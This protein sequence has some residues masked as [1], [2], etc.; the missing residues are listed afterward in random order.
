MKLSI[1]SLGLFTG[2]LSAAEVTTEAAKISQVT[3]Y[4]DRAEVVRS[5]KLNLPVGEHSLIFD[6]LPNS[7]DM[8]GIKVEGRGD[9]TLIDIRTETI[10][11]K[12]ATNE[13]VRTLQAALQAQELKRQ[14]IVAEEA[15]L[16]FRRSALDKI[17]NRLT[18]TGKESANPEMDPT[19]WQTF[20][21]FQNEQWTELDRQ[22][23][24]L[25]DRREVVRKETDRLNRELA[26]ARG[27][28]QKVRQVA[29]VHVDVHQAQ[30]V[31]LKLSY[32][33]MGP[34]WHPTYDLR[35]DTK[36]KTLSIGYHAEVRQFTGEDWHNVQLKLST[37]QPGIAGREPQMN[38]WFLSKAEVVAFGGMAA[39]T[40]AFELDPVSDSKMRRLRMSNSLAKAL[41]ADKSMGEEVEK[42]Q[43][44]R[45][46]KFEDAEITTGGTA[47][48]FTITRLSDIP[49]DNKVAKVSVT[50]A[51]FPSTFRYT[52]VPKLS[53]YV[54]L[55]TKAV[56]KTDFP[57]LPGPTA[58]F[59]DGA[60]VSNAS[61]D[62]VPAGQEF[63]TYLGV[64]Q[65]VSVERK[66]IGRREEVSG[67]FGTKTARTVID[68]VFK[69]KNGKPT[70]IELVIW[71]QLPI[72]NN[73]DIKVVIE[74]PA[75]EKDT[76]NLKLN[77]SKFLE[78]RQELNPGEKRDVP[79]RFA[80]ER[81][82]DVTVIGL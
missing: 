7:T 29:R 2:L 70:P 26:S 48:T 27:A 71:D 55:K 73:A 39:L 9:F 34:S 64:D 81:P 30:E 68:Q 42:I 37:A 74:E 59:L 77:E 76:E 61:L 14:E 1:L 40:P 21:A 50:E 75:Y 38:P 11:T 79:F 52:C 51:Q 46:V 43:N 49:S 80:V 60:F 78:W 56:N 35:A 4:A 22:S 32:L 6:N 45:A 28:G 57:F 82:E 18:S 19:K 69:V 23:F 63:W 62:L 3:V 24:V 36:A 44:K 12:E 53:P 41:P 8:D 33:V 58:I 65:S 67:V 17:F 66:E 10:Q 15:Q 5:I 31:E 47:A 16:A 72:S 13:K 20:L 54:Y 25:A